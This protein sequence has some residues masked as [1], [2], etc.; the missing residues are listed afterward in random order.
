MNRPVFDAEKAIEVLL[1]IA[2][3]SPN[4]YHALKVLYFADKDHLSKYGRLICGDSYVA[5]S[6]GPVPSGTYDLI[7]YIRDGYSWSVCSVEGI[8]DAF[9]MDG[10]S[11]RPLRDADT[12]FLSESD[13]ECLDD[14][15]A[16]YGN[17]RVGHLMAQSHD[18]AWRSADQ[19]DIMS[20]EAI[21]RTLPD[22][23]ALLEY[24]QG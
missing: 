18:D 7:K 15:I 24:L 8:E 23:D 22:A 20:L 10:H 19:N 14:A 3:R 4:L 6:K 13:I 17:M 9:E 16:Q 5:M 12:E 21:A 1:Y 2:E 11:I